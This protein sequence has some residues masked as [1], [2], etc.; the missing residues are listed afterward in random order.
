MLSQMED[1]ADESTHWAEIGVPAAAE[2]NDFAS[3]PILLLSKGKAYKCCRLKLCICGG[4]QVEAL[5]ANRD[6]DIL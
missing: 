5:G 4:L 3:D 2:A 6:L 1:A